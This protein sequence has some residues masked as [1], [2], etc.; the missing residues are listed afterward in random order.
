M[1][2]WLMGA[3]THEFFFSSATLQSAV[4]AHPARDSADARLLHSALLQAGH[5]GHFRRIEV[6]RRIDS[7]GPE[8]CLVV[9]Y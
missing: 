9:V 4:S 5:V 8:L 7:G 3:P 2:S 6:P 1:I